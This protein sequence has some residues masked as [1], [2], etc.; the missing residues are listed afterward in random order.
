MRN[1]RTG[2]QTLSLVFGL[3][4]LA[5]CQTLSNQQNLNNFNQHIAQGNYQAAADFALKAGDIKP[6]GSSEDLLWSLQAGSALSAAGELDLSTR[7]FDHAESMMKQEDTEN[8]GRKGLEKVTAALVNNNLN[9]YSPTVYDGVM[10]NTYKALNNI[11]LQDMQ[12][13][14]IEFNRAADRQRRAEETFKARIEA[15]KEKLAET[16]SQAEA[17][18]A[19]TSQLQFNK[20][21]QASREVIEEAYPEL[22]QWRAYP[23]F[24]NPYTDYLHGLYFML[25]SVDSSDYGKARESLRRVKGMVPSNKAVAT[26]HMVINKLR[27]GSWRKHKLNPAVWVIFENGEAPAVEE[28]LI[29]LPLF[30]LNDQVEYS[31]IALPKLKS[32]NRA[33]PHLELRANGKALGKTQLLASMDRVIQTEFKK[34]FPLKVTEAI[35]STLTKA[36]IQ[37]QA[38]KEMGL[39]GSLLAGVYQAA[40]TRADMRSWSSLPKEVQVARV[41]KP[42]SGSIELKAPGLDTPLKIALPDTRFTVIHVRATTPG[43]T[44][45]YQ[46]TGFD[47]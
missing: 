41:R 26:D 40:T 8:L 6:D 18:K 5:G 29:P 47:A 17:E 45:V 22:D 15:Q 2:V 24:V 32:R 44:P 25:A 27:T 39:A 11:F 42:A 20:S 1:L 3:G 4:L 23:D 46:V 30:L 13:A 36:F 33:Y 21:E 10:V 19:Q 12:N 35:A 34:E 7:V 38:K 14:R 16:R 43:S 9:R 28:T 31:Q 37:Y